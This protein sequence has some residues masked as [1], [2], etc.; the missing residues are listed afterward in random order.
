M[1]HSISSTIN[2]PRKN[3]SKEGV[4][5]TNGPKNA[6][7]NMITK[8]PVGKKISKGTFGSVYKLGSDEKY[9]MKTMMFNR[10]ENSEDKL[11][12]FFNEL[13]VG[14]NPRIS[15]VG[16]RIYAWRIIRDVEGYAT[17][18]QYI[19]DSFTGGNENLDSAILSNLKLCPLPN[20]PIY[21]MLRKTITKFWK[22]T[23]GYHGDLHTDNIAIVF[24]KKSKKI[25]KILIFDYGSHKK[26]KTRINSTTC[27]EDF[28]RIIDKEFHNRLRKPNTNVN[29]LNNTNRTLVVYPNRSQARRSNVNMLLKYLIKPNTNAA[30]KRKQRNDLAVQ[31]AAAAKRNRN[32]LVEGGNNNPANQNY[33]LMAVIAAIRKRNADIRTAAAATAKRNRNAAATPKQKSLFSSCFGGRCI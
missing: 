5:I 10:S 21:T 30:A 13:R 19:M 18:G 27:F 33:H 3:Y 24:N 26:F 14:K 4:T 7:F 31:T 9:V 6:K 28:L 1:W 16:P 20:D 22:I 29:Y 17:E 8:L 15:E 2:Y 32:M 11:K 12:I 25:K 23:K